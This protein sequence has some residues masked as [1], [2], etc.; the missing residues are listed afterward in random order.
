MNASMQF[1]LGASELAVILALVRAGN[2]AG[3]G[4]AMGIDASTVFRTV[5]RAEKALGQR[6]FERSRA[7]YR[8]TEI[9]Q[10]LAVHAESI[11]AELEA[12]RSAVL[13]AAGVVSGVVRI[14]TTDTILHGL[15][16]PALDPLIVRHPRLLLEVTAG[17]DLANLTRRETDIAIRATRRPPPHLVGR[18]LGPIRVALFA[19]RRGKGQ[20]KVAVDPRVAPWIA[21]DEALP[22]HPSV[23]WRRRHHPKVTPRLLLNSV[24]SVLEAIVAGAGIGI[25]PL[26]LTK[27]RKDVIALTGPLE[28]CETQL[29]MLSHPE[30]RHLRRISTV[31]AHLSEVI[32]LG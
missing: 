6:L 21:V 27:G 15:V 3:A 25:V 8:P 16:L 5:Q 31:V 1:Q 9:G 20:P 30:S 19:A 18:H 17:N 10:Q 4:H 12:A 11:E 24:H 23:Q 28:E 29:W 13:G 14:S 26:F 22:E 7:G 2:L 32:D